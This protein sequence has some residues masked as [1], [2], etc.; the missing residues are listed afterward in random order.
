[1]V[2]VGSP[3][4]TC[5]DCL[6]IESEQE[7]L[8]GERLTDSWEIRDTMD[9]EKAYSAWAYEVRPGIRE[10]WVL[11]LQSWGPCYGGAWVYAYMAPSLSGGWLIAIR[12]GDDVSCN[13]F[14]PTEEEAFRVWDRIPPVLDFQTCYD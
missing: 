11:A 2:D 8:H 10:R 1:M 5:P 4:V 12:G 7:R 13:Q 3:D 6:Y 14:F 9:D